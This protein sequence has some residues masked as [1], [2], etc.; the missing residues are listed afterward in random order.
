MKHSNCDFLQEY[1]KLG[2]MAVADTPNMTDNT[3]FIPHYCVVKESN[4][5]TH[6]PVDFDVSSKGS[7]SFSPNDF[8]ITS[9]KFQ[10]DII[11][12]ISHFRLHTFVFIADIC[13]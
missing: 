4:S 11:D 5:T 2:Y 3:Y 6:L 9:A 1:L 10:K 12:N 13:T 7:C 8:L